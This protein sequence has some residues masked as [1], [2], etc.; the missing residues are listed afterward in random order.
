MKVLLDTMV[1]L[2]EFKHK[3]PEKWKRIWNQ[4]FSNNYIM[5]LTEPLISEIFYQ[6]EISG[7]KGAAQSYLLR[8]KGMKNARVIPDKDGDKIAFA[9]GEIRVR[10]RRHN[11]SFVDSYTIAAAII[12][13]AVI[14]T[15]DHGVRDASK[16]EKC[17]VSYLPKEA[18]F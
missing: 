1:H 13:R 17:Q 12:E 10:H 16:Q 2:A 4:F 15:A 11:I 8:L 6:I 14:Y 9:A 7:G 3:T 5:I 18:L